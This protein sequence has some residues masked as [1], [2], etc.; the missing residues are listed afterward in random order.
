MRAF[1]VDGMKVFNKRRFEESTNRITTKRENE[2]END[3][4]SP[5]KH[6]AH[7]SSF[8]VSEYP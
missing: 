1:E 6:D 7:R 4:S 3:A 2:K 8:V 5:E